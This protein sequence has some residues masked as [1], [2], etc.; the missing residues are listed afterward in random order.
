MAVKAYTT[1]RNILCKGLGKGAEMAV[2]CGGEASVPGIF[3]Y[4]TQGAC[5]ER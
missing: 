2:L 5:M 3:I 4:T 1:F